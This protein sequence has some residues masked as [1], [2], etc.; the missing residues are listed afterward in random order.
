MSPPAPYSGRLQQVEPQ[1][2]DYNGH[3]NMAYY[4][5]LFDRAGDEAFSAMGLGPN[6]V[7][8]RNATFFTVEAHVTYLRELLIGDEV[9]VETQILDHDAKRV[10]YVQSMF[11]ARDGYLACLSEIMVVHVSL[12]TRRTAPFPPD[13]LSRIA[14]M[15]EAHK[16]LPVPAQV[17]HKIGIPRK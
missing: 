16:G 12:E 15:A 9:R 10:H 3:L 17:G 2:A 11:H 5:V 4:H 14:E 6:Y 8:E 13:V 7:K 1:W